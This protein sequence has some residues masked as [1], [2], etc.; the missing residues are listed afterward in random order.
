VSLVIVNGTL[1]VSTVPELVGSVPSVVY[2]ITAPTV[3]V[4]SVTSKLAPL[5]QLA[6]LIVGFSTGSATFVTSYASV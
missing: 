5:S 2:F 1:Y 6:G 4:A 3:P